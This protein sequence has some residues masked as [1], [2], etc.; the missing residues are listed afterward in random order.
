MHP[1]YFPL[2]AGVPVA[3]V[4]DLELADDGEGVVGEEPPG[5]G[6]EVLPRHELGGAQAL[7]VAAGVAEHLLLGHVHHERFLPGG[8]EER[9]LEGRRHGLRLFVPPETHNRAVLLLLSS[10]YNNNMIGLEPPNTSVNK[11]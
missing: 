2:P 9:E 4:E 1:G 10:H 8:V 7:G 11:N 3:V 6:Q 5:A